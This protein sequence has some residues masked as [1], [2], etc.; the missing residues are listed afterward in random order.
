MR[1]LSHLLVATT[2]LVSVGGSIAQ[3]KVVD[4]GAV[5][6]PAI[7]LHEQLV[8]FGIAWPEDLKA[9]FKALDEEYASM[10]AFPSLPAIEAMCRILP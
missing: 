5:L 1:A 8:Q 3:A 10:P 9:K 6:K 4:L 2:F 7:A